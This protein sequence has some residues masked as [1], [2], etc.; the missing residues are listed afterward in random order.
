MS[1]TRSLSPQCE[2]LQLLFVGETHDYII[3]FE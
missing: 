2:K 1:L 3:I